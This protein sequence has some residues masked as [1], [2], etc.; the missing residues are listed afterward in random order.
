MHYS[1]LFV[2]HFEDLVFGNSA[3]T[4]IF[5]AAEVLDF[6]GPFFETIGFGK[7]EAAVSIFIARVADGKVIRGHQVQKARLSSKSWSHLV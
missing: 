3:V 5:H 7:G 4:S 6:N 1:C 2:G